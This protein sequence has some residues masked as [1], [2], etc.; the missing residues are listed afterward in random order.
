MTLLYIF[1]VL[2]YIVF[3]FVPNLHQN[4]RT[5]VS[6][7]R[8]QDA[9]L[10]TLACSKKLGLKWL[11]S[12]FVKITEKKRVSLKG[13]FFVVFRSPVH[14]EINHLLTCVESEFE[15][16]KTRQIHKQN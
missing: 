12:K 13:V 14:K 16:D 5:S 2:L 6:A 10:G 8:V 9:T 11:Y 3:H 15:L 4:T 7:E 1:T